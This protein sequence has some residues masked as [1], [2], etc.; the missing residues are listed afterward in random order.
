M[1]LPGHLAYLG[2]QAVELNFAGRK[3]YICP[4]KENSIGH[5]KVESCLLFG[6]EVYGKDFKSAPTF[7]PESLPGMSISPEHYSGISLSQAQPVH[8]NCAPG[9]YPRVSG[10][11]PAT[12]LP[13]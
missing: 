12:G 6:F 13:T 5:I 9:V 3:C 2:V 11:R 4:P 10:S 8:P 1:A 7:P